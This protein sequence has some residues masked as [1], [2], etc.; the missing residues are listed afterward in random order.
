MALLAGNLLCHEQQNLLRKEFQKFYAKAVSYLQENLPFDALVLKYL[1]YLHPEKKN[2]SGSTDVICNLAF[3]LTRMFSKSYCKIFQVSS[4]VS[5]D[6]V[7]DKTKLQC[8]AY[9][10]ETIPSDYYIKS[11]SVTDTI[12][13]KKTNSYLSYA[14]ELCDLSPP[15]EELRS[16]Y[17][18]I[19]HY[20]R[21]VGGI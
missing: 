20:C 21:K 18:R 13:V 16:K 11:D 5:T 4:T 14:L 2:N 1:Q 12:S 6:E 7:C 3:R 10:L 15:I 19:E 8:V 17:V 9:Q